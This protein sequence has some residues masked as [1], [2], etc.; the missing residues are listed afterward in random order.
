[1]IPYLVQRAK[2]SSNETKNGIDK[3]LSFDYMGSS[4]FEWGALP[5]S[6]KEI[7]GQIADY[8][9]H[10]F[11]VVGRKKKPIKLNKEDARRHIWVDSEFKPDV[12]LI[13]VFCH[14]DKVG[15]VQ[16]YLDSLAANKFTLKESSNFNCFVRGEEG[17][18][19]KFDF[20][21][22]IENHLMFWKEND[23]FANKFKT[24]VVGKTP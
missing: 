5:K 13:T 2:F 10:Q 23:G 12:K 4:E 18:Y 20:W 19:Y 9:Y 7:R 22:D 1:M 8:V 6:L 3:I 14:K 24:L 15:E 21:W 16:E 11:K 17:E